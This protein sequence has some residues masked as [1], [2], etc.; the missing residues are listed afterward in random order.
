MITP[1]NKTRIAILGAGP[2]GVEA[3]AFAARRGFDVHV[4]ERGEVGEHVS[5][6]G[7]VTFFSPWSLNRSAWG[8]DLLREQDKTL[9]AGGDFPTGQDYLEQYLLPL[10][11]HPLL[12]G[13]IHTGHE[14]LGVSRKRALKGDFIARPERGDE[15]FLLHL[16]SARS[17]A[18][19]EADIVLDTTGSYRHPNALGAGGLRALGEASAA[20][21]IERYV[22]DVS[23]EARAL[24]EG[25]RTLVIGAGYSAVTSVRALSELEAGTKT[26]W[27]MRSEDSPYE[28]LEG[29]TLPQRNALA[30]FGNAASRG[31]VESVSPL[32]GC[33]VHRI[34][35]SE[36]GGLVVHVQRG[37]DV[38][39]VRVDRIVANVGYHPDV[40]I[41][42]ELQVHHCWASE[43]PMK[44]AASMLAAGGSADCLA[45]TSA[46]AETLRNP[47]PG[48]FILGAKSHGRGSS[49]LLR[50]G[51]EQIGEV[52][53]FWPDA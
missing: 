49:F 48:F 17:E 25:K 39:E 13:R 12:S 41:T 44:L 6:W 36:A 29:D 52:A 18:Y 27:L 28:V 3:A 37:G 40:A 51:L 1:K 46:G 21:F 7:H 42:R 10:S 2:I 34:E 53:S 24:Y 4:Y 26:Y 9:S 33:C 30:R 20:P 11:E 23:G 8:E 22:P 38:R 5:W 31:E 47:E 16:K 35:V 43:G 32:L 15:P 50:L 19:V 14:V 45:Q